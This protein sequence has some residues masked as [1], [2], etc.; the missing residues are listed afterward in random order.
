VGALSLTLGKDLFHNT[1][2]SATLCISPP[3]ASVVDLEI[4]HA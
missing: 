4:I 3:F 2:R 1:A